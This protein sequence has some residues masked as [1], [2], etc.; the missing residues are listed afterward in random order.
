MSIQISAD[1]TKEI[2]PYVE[3][4]SEL[5]QTAKAF[6]DVAIP[7]SVRNLPVWELKESPERVKNMLNKMGVCTLW[8]LVHLD[9]VKCRSFRGGFF[10]SK[11]R[12]SELL[13]AI[14]EAVNL[15]RLIPDGF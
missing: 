4:I 2:E 12:I 15:F 10:A 3:K 14:K 9:I 7:D 5:L 13:C 1:K 11:R 8:E 6:D